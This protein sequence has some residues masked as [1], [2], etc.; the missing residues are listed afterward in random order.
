MLLLD[1]DRGR[2]PEYIPSGYRP[3]HTGPY[4]GWDAYITSRPEREPR[5]S[6]PG[7]SVAYLD[8]PRHWPMESRPIGFGREWPM[9]G[10]SDASVP[11]YREMDRMPGNRAAAGHS[12]S[13]YLPPLD[14]EAAETWGTRMDNADGTHGAHWT[15]DQV[16]QLMAQRGINCPL[17]AFYAALNAMY[18]DYVGV[19]KKH[20]VGGSMD[21]YVDMA[22]AWLDDKDAVPDK[23]AAYWQYIVKH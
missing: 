14:A 3:E 12:E 10:G 2:Y 21:Y 20:G 5:P 8:E 9:M 18:S 16:R 7:P 15:M 22:L 6:Y 17:P 4:M 23:A 13:T 11:G 1:R 19:A